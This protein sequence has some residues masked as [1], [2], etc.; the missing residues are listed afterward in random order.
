MSPAPYRVHRLIQ[1][2]NRDP[3]LVETFRR[4]PEAVFKAY[5]IAENERQLLRQG[6]PR[7]LI[8]LGVHPN[9]Q[10]KFLRIRRAAEGSGPSPLASYLRDLGHGG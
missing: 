6:T 9:L 10:M 5:D 2:L 3:R 7:A 8:A 4:E 1:D